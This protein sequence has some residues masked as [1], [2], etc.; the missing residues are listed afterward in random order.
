[1][2]HTE[3]RIARSLSSGR[4][5]RA[6]PVGAIP[7]TFSA[8]P[9]DQEAR[10]LADVYPSR[11][12][13][14]FADDPIAALADAAGAATAH[15]GFLQ[16]QGGAVVVPRKPPFSEIHFGNILG[17]VLSFSRWQRRAGHYRR[18]I[19]DVAGDC[20]KCDMGKEA[21]YAEPLTGGPFRGRIR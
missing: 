2:R 9:A 18:R 10:S 11:T 5:L 6:G 20:V 1:M 14:R 3:P 7:A 8:L 12:G 19:K 13:A 21:D 17:F 15:T 16:D 4:P